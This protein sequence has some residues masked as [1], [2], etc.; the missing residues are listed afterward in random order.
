MSRSHRSLNRV[1]LLALSLLALLALPGG[2]CGGRTGGGGGSSNDVPTAE[3]DDVT[4]EEETAVTIVLI[5]RDADGGEGDELVL[6]FDVVTPPERGT[7]QEVGPIGDDDD[8]D[9]APADDDDDAGDEIPT[10][11]LVYEYT[12]EQDFFGEDSFGFVVVDEDEEPSE[13]V[14]VRVTVTNVNDLPTADDQS[15]VVDEDG[16]VQITLEGDDIDGDVLEFQVVDTPD[17][18]SLGGNPPNVTYTPDGDYFGSDSFRFVAVDEEAQSSQATVSISVASVNDVPIADATATQLYGPTD[19]PVTGW[20]V[21]GSFLS[22]SVSSQPTFGSTGS[23]SSTGNDSATIRYTPPLDWQGDDAF[24]F[25]VD[26]GEDTSSPATVDITVTGEPFEVFGFSVFDTDT[27]QLDGVVHAG[28]TGSELVVGEF[29]IGNNGTLVVEGSAP[30]IVTALGDLS[31]FGDVDLSGSNA[32][33][34]GGCNS[35]GTAG[36]L[37]GPG[38]QPGG[39]GGGLGTGSGSL[40]GAAGAGPGG[41]SAGLSEN[42]GGGG[43]G[44]ASSGT[45]GSGLGGNGGPSYASLPPL[46]GGS[47]GGGGAVDN[48]SPSSLDSGD[49]GGA[50]GGGGGG[51]ISIWFGG[52]GNVTGTIDS[53][54][55][56]GGSSSCGGGGGGGGSGGAIEI[57]GLS[58]SPSISGT[59]NVT[60][61]TSNGT[62]GTGSAGRTST[63]IVPP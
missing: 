48:D 3:A 20:D 27:G 58:S 39:A 17:F 35:A 11:A 34:T 19:I 45:G 7:L 14:T 40:N 10:R 60:G 51:A 50:G 9:S 15:A 47:G 33:N 25:V 29:T 21:E 24:S 57:L 26:D 18:G 44:H 37:P 46:L 32:S 54:G 22:F 28:W 16:S 63:G 4:T 62:G 61:G 13:E 6:T 59:L 5:G 30:L 1:P 55:G 38:G 31:I 2:S 42:G 12:P 43:A 36:G 8:D 49:D 56:N 52:S 41:G 53:S 23:V